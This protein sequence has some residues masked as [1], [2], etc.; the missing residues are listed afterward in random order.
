MNPLYYLRSIAFGTFLAIELS[1]AV[2]AQDRSS[3][4]EQY[5]K[6]CV[7]VNHFSG[8]VLV[9]KD[10]ETLFANGYG[11]ANAEHEVPNT[12]QTKFRLGSITKQFTAMAILILNEHGKLKLDDP[13]GK[14][15]DDSPKAWEGVTI[16]H[17]LTHTGGV[18]SYTDDIL[19][20]FKMM[21]PETVNSMIKRFRDKP[22]D[23]KPG[24]KFHYSNSGYFLLGAIIEKLS[25]ERYE[26]FLK[27]SIFDPLGMHDTGY[28]HYATLLLHRAS[29]YNRADDGLTNAQ[30]LDMS[31]PYSAG[32]L[33]STV[34]DLARWD[35]ALREG[36]L[37]SKESYA[38]MYTPVKDDYAYGWVVSTNKGRKE[39]GHGGG[40]NGFVTDILRYPDQKLCVVVLCNVQ[41]Q[42]PNQVTHD[43]A[44][45][46]LG[47][48]YEMPKAH[49]VTKVDPKIYDAYA[50]RYEIGPNVIAAFSRDGDR[51]WVEVTG[52]P[53]VEVFP[54]SDTS[55]FLKAVDA[56]VRFLKDDTGKVTHAV[57]KQG[58]RDMKAKRLEDKPAVDAKAGSAK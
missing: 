48:P 41:P 45:I 19:Y 7:A 14:Y 23:F 15:L 27:K 3:Q 16:H 55:F 11:F 10:N 35:R 44:A 34:E 57:I 36:K 42:S 18:P 13:I 4:F 50:G 58:G 12:T 32:S 29:G 24:E 47:E 8:A 1:A 28:D 30:Y 6:T 43:L 9:S 37:I 21:M 40:I 26:A 46:A 25:G 2:F 22:L 52:Q 38:K 54:E 17:L 39:I 51:F 53:K 5:M 49:K 33:Y 20:S 31:Q 56:T